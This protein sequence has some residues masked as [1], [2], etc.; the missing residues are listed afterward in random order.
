MRLSCLDLS[1]EGRGLSALE[2]SIAINFHNFLWQ[3]K[4][5]LGLKDRLDKNDDSLRSNMYS[6]LASNSF[7]AQVQR[8]WPTS[9]VDSPFWMIW[10]LLQ[11]WEKLPL[12]GKSDVKIQHKDE[13]HGLKLYLPICRD[14]F[15]LG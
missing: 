4:S 9:V 8:M 2:T 1:T 6:T 14:Q 3:I 11:Y 7:G 10:Q 13:N 5:G 12:F 15:I